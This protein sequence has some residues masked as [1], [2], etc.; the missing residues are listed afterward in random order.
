MTEPQTYIDFHVLQTVPPANL[1]RDDNGDPKEAYFGGV[2]R[3]RVSSQAWKR[4]CRVYFAR[5]NPQGDHAMRTKKIA[6]QLAGRLAERAELDAE[7]AARIATAALQPLKISP[8]KKADK[9]AYLLFFNRGQL[10]AIIDLFLEDVAQLRELDD[11]DL[12]ARLKDLPVQEALN[13][14]HPLDVGLFGRMVADIPALNV[15]AATQVAHAISTH[16]VELEMDFYTAVD[17]KEEDTTGAGMMGTVGFNSATLY[18]YA[19]V[20][21]HQ[22]EDNLGDPAAA[23]DGVRLFAEA[24]ARSMPTGKNTSFAHHTRPSLVAVVIRGDQPVNLVSAFENPVTTTTGIA[25]ASA[26]RLAGEHIRSVTQWGD[27]PLFTGVCHTL[28]ADSPEA[29]EVRKAFGD[30]LTFPDLLEATLAHV[31]AAQ[32]TA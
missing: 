3:S 20:G 25:A 13:Q 17:D 29:I 11:E 31:P 12:A 21:L 28:E 26:R 15:D 27:T 14:G 16:A 7:T 23:R 2:R 1:N 6:E 18:R 22:L 24:F 8:G 19:T 5:Q 4:A 32:E 10:D 30:N 9:T